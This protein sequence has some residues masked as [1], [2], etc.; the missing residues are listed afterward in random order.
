MKIKRFFSLLLIGGL[1]AA[2][3]GGGSNDPVDTST[4]PIVTS[5]SPTNGATGIASGNITITLTFDQNISFVTSNYNK[6]TLGSASVTA[7]SVTSNSGSYNTLSITATGLVKGTSYT[8]SIPAGLIKGSGTLYNTAISLSFTTIAAATMSTVPCDK[9]ATAKTKSLYTYLLSIYGKKTLSA[10]MADV[11][12]N[13]T[14]ADKIKALTGK[15]PAVNCFDFI[16]MNASPANW[17]NYNDITPVTNWAT[18]GGI[19]S[20]GW[21]FCVLTKEGADST[22]VTYDPTKTTF[23]CKNIFTEGSWENKY[24]YK[25]MDKTCAILLKLQNAGIAAL[26]RPFHEAAGNYYAKSYKGT[27]WFWW[28]YDGPEYYVKLWRL[29]YTYF[30]SKGIHNLIWNWTTQNANGDATAYDYDTAYYPGDDYVDIVGID[31][32]G[33][34]A[35]SEYNE[36]TTIESRFGNKMHSLSECG[37]NITDD[38]TKNTLVSTQSTISAQWSKGCHWIYFMPWYD[39]YYDNGKS[40]TNIMCSDSFWTDAMS[41][42]YVITRDQVSY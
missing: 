40:T 16:H 4:A 41:Q 14:G 12:W 25:Q 20:L 9:S 18:A 19:V 23:R 7:A 3:G 5:S 6:I 38:G 22:S 34:T 42:S 11:A 36:W 15:Y 26:W 28:G 21:H 1:L 24:F 33:R 31:L 27:S 10:A 29:M 32:Y 37:N 13:Q 17:I 39:Y 30:Q 35:D 8:L 2:C